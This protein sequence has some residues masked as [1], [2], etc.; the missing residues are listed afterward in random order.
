MLNMGKLEIN[1]GAWLAG[2]QIT[3]FQLLK[4]AL[5]EAKFQK[6]DSC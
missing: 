3:C 5:S 2:F 4:E 6:W 1:L